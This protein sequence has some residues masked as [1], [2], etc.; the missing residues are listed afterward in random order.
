M[1]MS[2]EFTIEA[3]ASDLLKASGERVTRTRIVVL[4]VLLAAPRALT[5]A[6]IVAAVLGHGLAL[7]R[8]TLYR[9]LEWLVA[10]GHAHR[11]EG[12][13]RVWRFNAVSEHSKGHAHFHCERCARVYC[14]EDLRPAVAVG[15]PPGYTLSRS[16]LT[17]FGVCAACKNLAGR[18]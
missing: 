14:L 3:S 9:V 7:D 1:R 4:E 8:V 18:D 5:H 2:S 13:D 10:R 17:L 12:H 11:V 6:E 16:E 15:L